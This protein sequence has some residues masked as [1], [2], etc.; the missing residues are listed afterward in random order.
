L[1]CLWC[2]IERCAILVVDAADLVRFTF[3]GNCIETV[4]STEEEGT[5]IVNLRQASIPVDE[6]SRSKYHVSCIT[7]WT[8]YPAN[9]KSVLEEGR[10]LRNK[11]EKFARLTNA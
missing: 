2:V 3:A 11:N 6:S 5:T 4:R 1:E 10:D 8:F 7:G 9:L